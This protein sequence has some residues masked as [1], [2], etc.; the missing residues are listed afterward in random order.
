MDG[1]GDF[2]G[3]GKADILWRNS[4]S[5]ADSLRESNRSGGVTGVGVWSATKEWQVGGIGA[6]NGE[7]TADIS[8]RNSPSGT[9]CLCM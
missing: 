3:D 9:T 4:T 7:G 6:V 5:G 1:I 8:W 2:N